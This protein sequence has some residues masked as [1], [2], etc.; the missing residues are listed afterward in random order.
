MLYTARKKKIIL[1]LLILIIIAGGINYFGLD[2]YRSYREISYL[3]KMEKR[4][5]EAMTA[6]TYGGKTP[7]ETLD[8]FVEALKAGDIEL[9]GKY[10]LSD[11]NLSRDHWLDMLNDIKNRDL[12]DEMAKDLEELARPVEGDDSNDFAFE[13]L[14][15]DGTVVVLIDLQL[16]KYSNVWKI[17]SL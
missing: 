9:A 10:F 4:Y 17:E 13:I 14:G 5:V 15:S 7:Q 6:D 12:L 8:M 1:G 2:W 16:N 11:E 3:E